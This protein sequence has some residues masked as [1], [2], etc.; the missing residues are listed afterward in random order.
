MAAMTRRNS[1][2]HHNTSE[3]GSGLGDTTESEED[4]TPGVRKTSSIAPRSVSHANTHCVET[5]SKSETVVRSVMSEP[6]ARDSTTRTNSPASSLPSVDERG[7]FHKMKTVKIHE[8]TDNLH[9]KFAEF[10][11]GITE[12]VDQDVDELKHDVQKCVELVKELLRQEATERISQYE[13]IEKRYEHIE[14]ICREIQAEHKDLHGKHKD[15]HGRHADLQQRHD[16][17]TN[18]HRDALNMKATLADDHKHMKHRVDHLETMF[19]AWA[20]KHTREVESLTKEHN[21]FKQELAIF[22]DAHEQHLEVEESLDTAVKGLTAAAEQTA[23]ALAAAKSKLDQMHEGVLGCE[24]HCA[25]SDAKVAA[26]NERTREFEKRLDGNSAHSAKELSHQAKELE[27]LRSDQH[28]LRAECSSFKADHHAMRG[29]HNGLKSE[30]NRLLDEH[31]GLKADHDKV[32]HK[33]GEFDSKLN[34][35]LAEEAQRREEA[36]GHHEQLHSMLSQKHDAQVKEL[37]GLRDAHGKHQQDLTGLWDVHSKHQQDLGQFKSNVETALSELA[38]NTSV[39]LKTTRDGLDQVLALLA[40]VQ[41]AWRPCMRGSPTSKS[42][43][44]SRIGGEEAGSPE[45]PAGIDL[46]KHMAGLL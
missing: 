20:D 1:G 11:H 44:T 36:L 30:L 10:V 26:L 8:F 21:N 22:N 42:R 31:H 37:T 7:K 34:S 39:E 23:K 25:A 2:N 18:K 35:R 12:V 28:G 38:H 3:S 46:M 15:L 43:R 17:L 45:T 27:R 29:E 41:R 32:K 9:G 13:R 4:T 6:H 40:G 14:T 19:G 16:D 5:R 24:Q 33:F